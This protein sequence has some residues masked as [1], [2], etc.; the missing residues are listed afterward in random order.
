[1]TSLP[2]WA[3]QL[4][5]R[6]P[7]EPAPTAADPLP[8]W[9]LDEM[10]RVPLWYIMREASAPRRSHPFLV[11]DEILK[12]P[13]Q[14]EEILA[15]FEGD[16]SRV[17][18]LLGDRGTERVIF[19]GCGSAFFTAMH[20]AFLWERWSQM[21]TVAIESYE[22]LNYFPRVVP[23]RTLVV[24]HSGTG[25][26]IET[27]QA[28]RKARGEGLLTL[29]LT[30]TDSSPLLEECDES[31]V[32]VTH[33]GCGPCISVVSTRLLLQTMLALEIGAPG[34]RRGALAASAKA[35]PAAGRAFLK[36]FEDSV[37]R[38]AHK[39][40]D[41]EAFFVVGSGP[42]YFTAREGTLKIEEQSLMVG[43]AYRPGDF[44]H[45][46]LS[47]LRPTRLVVVV[48]ADGPANERTVDV[49]RAARAGGAP[50]LAI[51]YG[52]AGGLAD[53]ADETWHLEGDVNEDVA[54][55]LLTLP[56]QLL[57]YYMGTERGRNP[58]T[59]ATDREANTRAWLTAFPL[60]TH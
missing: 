52:R 6:H 60:G 48:A 28:L 43:K 19:T 53:Y 12:E 1:V 40:A 5:E 11:H 32:Y 30:N 16:V 42:N 22:L 41:V 34:D 33:Q 21:S 47:L 13:D 56:L 29:A 44:H 10:S 50:T 3:Q 51:E 27:L 58:D 49:L 23:E 37:Q 9:L 46:A 35:L 54:P 20:G 14:W 2:R 38:F 36:G 18:K 24:A 25:G 31:L 15:T 45:D 57:G 59:L 26:T 39:T 8:Q 17:A 4:L 55:V 7:G